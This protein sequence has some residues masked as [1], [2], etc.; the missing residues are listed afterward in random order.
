MDCLD[1][2]SRIGS[3]R[4]LQNL[5]SSALFHHPAFLHNQ[6][7]AADMP[8]ADFTESER[9]EGRVLTNFE[10]KGLAAGRVI[11]DFTYQAVTLN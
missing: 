1:Q 9:F 4:I 10:K 11:H 2:F 5:F 8:H 3:L 7:M 6:D